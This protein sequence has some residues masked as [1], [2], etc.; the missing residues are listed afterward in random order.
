MYMWINHSVELMFRAVFSV[1]CMLLPAVTIAQSGEDTRKRFDRLMDQARH[2]VWHTRPMGRIIRDTG[3]FFADSPYTAGLLDRAA[4][5]VLVSDLMQFDCVLFVEAVVALARGIA[6]QDY[7]FGGYEGRLESM[8]YRHG[9]RNGYC[10]RL[11]YFSEWISDNDSRGTVREITP[12]LGGQPLRKTLNF[13]SSHRNS[14]PRL[15]VSDSL[16]AGIQELEA[17][18]ADITLYHIPQD[19]ISVVYPQLH[20]GDILAL[21]TD[22]RGLDVTHTGFAF[23]QPDGRFGLLHASPNGG[24]IVSDDLAAYVRGNRSQI[25]I[26]VARPLDPR[27]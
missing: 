20:D 26:M 5:E 8:R 19:R 16:F 13:M 9:H 2:E 21:S 1:L 11:H 14:Y 27:H 18:L 22:I 3:L 12:D 10:S 7:T 6:V 25:G 4:E 17:D 15:L 23:A 24:V